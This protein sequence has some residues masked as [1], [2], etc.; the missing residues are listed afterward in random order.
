MKTTVL[1]TP[2]YHESLV[3]PNLG[4]HFKQIVKDS[5]KF[6]QALLGG[7]PLYNIGLN[8]SQYIHKQVQNSRQQQCSAQHSKHDHMYKCSILKLNIIYV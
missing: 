2:Q 5:S 8:P 6:Q 4:K 7:S 1:H 3:G